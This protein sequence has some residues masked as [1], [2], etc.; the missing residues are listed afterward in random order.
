[1]DNGIGGGPTEEVSRKISRKIQ[2]DVESSG[3][4]WHPDKS[5]WEPSQQ[6]EILG[7]LVDLKKGYFRVPERI[8]KCLRKKLKYIAQSSKSTARDIAQVTGT[9]V[10]M[11]LAL[12]PVARLW[13]RGLYRFIMQASAWW[14]HDKLDEDATREIVS[15]RTTLKYV[16]ANQSGWPTQNQ[17]SSPT[18]MQVI[19]AGEATVLSL[20]VE[21]PR[22]IGH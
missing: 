2:I 17:R 4:L 1:L 8:I 7:F 6:G 10:S 12:G 19:P 5:V 20:V 13:T 16:M 18:L 21:L 3:F 14:E 15:G 9:I 22:E 11:G